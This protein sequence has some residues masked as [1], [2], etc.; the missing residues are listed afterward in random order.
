ML[1]EAGGDGSASGAP[2]HPSQT[3]SK[4]ATT[5]DDHPGTSTNSKEKGEEDVVSQ[6]DSEP[7][8]GTASEPAPGYNLVQTPDEGL[9]V[10]VLPSWGIETG[11]DSEK[12]A[13]TNTWSYYAGEHL[14]S[15]ITTA[16]NLD[17]WYATGT[18]GA[19]VVASKALAQYTDYDLIH[20]L[21]Y[22]NKDQ[23]CTKGPYEDYD[24]SPYFGKIQTWYDCGADGAT[25]FTVAA[26][27]EGRECVVVVDA[28][29]SEESDRKAVEHLI[30]TFEVDCGRVTSR[31]LEAPSNDTSPSPSSE[32]SASPS[33]SP[34]PAPNPAPNRNYSAPDPNVPGNGS[35]SAS[36]M[37]AD[38]C[39][40]KGGHP[41]PP[42]SDGDGDGDGC[43]GE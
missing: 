22:A 10:E 14:T 19:Y 34:S 15:S 35:A 38:D 12:D 26:S 30:D 25:T 11:E 1:G 39:L 13:A 42:G 27:P 24:R 43:A 5:S 8:S 29:I 20:S 37:S 32:S 31:P 2:P 9:T 36:Q 18:S 21:L 33:A 3:P 40:N 6:E 16:P 41:V 28:R 4:P 23:T 7:P 17:A